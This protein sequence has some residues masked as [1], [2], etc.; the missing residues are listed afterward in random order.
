MA[1]R[2][3]VCV[4]SHVAHGA[5]G[6]RIMV[7]ALQAMGFRVVE[8]A[9]IHLSWHPGMTRR[10]GAPSRQVPEMADFAA[11]CT[12]ISAAPFAETIAGIVT[13]YL[14][15]ARQAPVIASMIAAIKAAN[16]AA[17]HLCDPVSGD[18]GGL[19]VAPDIAQAIAAHLW[20]DADIVTPNLFEHGWMSA[21]AAAVPDRVSHAARKASI[22]TSA[23]VGEATISTRIIAPGQEVIVSHDRH[24]VAPNGTGDLLSALMLGHVVRGLRPVE[25]AG[26]AADAVA[27]AVGWAAETGDYSLAPERIAAFLDEAEKGERRVVAA[28]TRSA[29][30]SA[31]ATAGVDGCKS[32]WVAA[33]VEAGEVRFSIH[34]SFAALVSSYPPDAI[35]AVDMPIGLPDRIIGPGRAAEQAVRRLLGRKVS[36]VFS[37]IARPAVEALLDYDDTC[38]LALKHSVPARKISSQG[39]N[40]LPKVRELDGVLRADAGLLARVSETHPEV[41]LAVLRGGPILESKKTPLGRNL[42]RAF[43]SEQGVHLPNTLPKISGAADD[44]LIDAAICLVVADRIAAGAAQPHP[45]PPVVDAHGIPIAIWT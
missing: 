18:D 1:A 34:G 10:F 15:D 26:R 16:P 36:S 44:D 9:T 8:V 17:L 12:A 28:I 22:I 37:M 3:I 14:G 35:I 23:D 6:N 39:F 32:G 2:L 29:Q 20:R 43:L 30:A 25:A 41:A 21:A 19:Y 4:S 13:G 27:A 38:D 24:A 31:R 40:I 7:P 33:H 45:S 5:V 42:R 11:L